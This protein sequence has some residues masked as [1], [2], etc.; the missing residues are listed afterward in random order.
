MTGTALFARK[1]NVV[2]NKGNVCELTITFYSPEEDKKYDCYLA[3]VELKC[4][5]FSRTLRGGGED[6]A[7]AFFWLP[8]VVTAYLIGQRRFGFEAY[9]L[10]PG[11]L[12]YADFWTYKQ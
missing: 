1:C 11:D 5:F 12:D 4:D 6:E 7:Q 2:D 8:K 10:E 9:W 3:F